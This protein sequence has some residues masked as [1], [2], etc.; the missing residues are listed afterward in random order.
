LSSGI[1]PA[2]G[3]VARTGTAR[4]LTAEN[5]ADAPISAKV[6]DA[7]SDA[8][9][10]ELPLAPENDVYV[11]RTQLPPGAYRAKVTAAFPLNAIIVTEA[12]LTAS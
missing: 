8:L 7:Q 10:Q 6:S 9:A 1:G 11:A 3:F 4:I 5:S 12:L 2:P